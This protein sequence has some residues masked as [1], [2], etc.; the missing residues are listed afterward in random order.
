MKAEHKGNEIK[1]VKV[2][3]KTKR[4]KKSKKAKKVNGF[5]RTALAAALAAAAFLVFFL[6]ES[7][8]W[9]IFPFNMRA[10][11]RTSASDVL[12]P[13]GN[14]VP[15]ESE[16]TA[17]GGYSP[18]DEGSAGEADRP[19]LTVGKAYSGK[20]VEENSINILV[21][22]EDKVSYLYDTIGIMSI[23]KEK[24]TMKLIMIPRDTY[25]EYNDDIL[26]ALK[27]AGKAGYPGIY[28]INYTHHIGTLIDYEGK[29]TSKTISFLAD[30]IKEKFGVPVNDY[31]KV[32]TQGFVKLVDLFG[33]VEI[34][35]PYDMNYEDPTQDLYIHLEKGL[36]VLKG[37]QA[38]G[39][40]RFRQGWRKDGT[41]FEVGDTER[42]KNQINFMKAFIQQH[43]SIRNINKLP[44]MLGILGKNVKTSMSAADVLT[45]YIGLAKD[46]VS[47]KYQIESENLEGR[48]IRINGSAYLEV[49]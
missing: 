19:V 5:K 32:N 46:I 9:G 20:L 24:G 1:K 21:I 37:S 42:K 15:P 26:G 4:V 28:K 13:D 27:K 34:K 35:V 40:V 36:Q 33:G 39:F 47:D 16:D 29:F 7:Y 25:I 10:V 14:E 43:G 6:V 38:E 3:G 11:E 22:G 44:G 2:T 18:T 31:I 41:F 17:D 12:S 45:T 8:I 48:Q 23:S 30:V 49:E